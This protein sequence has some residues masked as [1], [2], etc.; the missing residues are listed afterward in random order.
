MYDIY[1]KANL[2]IRY[3]YYRRDTYVVW[4]TI[5]LY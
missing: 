3:E 1:H 5:Q 2:Q 4:K